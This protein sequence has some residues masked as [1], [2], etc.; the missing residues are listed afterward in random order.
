MSSASPRD[1]I[2]NTLDKYSLGSFCEHLL[3]MLG[4]KPEA[5]DQ[6]EEKAA[7][8]SALYLGID[9]LEAAKGMFLVKS[10]ISLDSIITSKEDQ[11]HIW[12]CCSEL[13]KAQK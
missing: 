2:K 10:G 12:K 6:V 5:Q 4:I 3:G 1:Q 11:E 13:L 7:D 9:S 8:E